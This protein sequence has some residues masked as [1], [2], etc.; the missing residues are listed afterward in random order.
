MQG[1][2]H[3][4]LDQMLGIQYPIIMAPMFLVSNARMVI[5]ALNAGITG[6]IPALN[7]RSVRE[8]K[9]AIREIKSD[10]DKPFGIN[11]IVNKSNILL[12]KQLDVVAEEKIGFVITSLGKPQA[13]I[14]RL[15]DAGIKVFCDVINLEHALKCEQLGADALIAVN[16]Q[17]GGHLGNLPPEELIPLLKKKTSLP[18][19]S[20]GGVSTP[21]DVKEILDMGADGLSIGSVFIASHEA[22]VADEYKEAIVNYGAEDIVITTRLS[23]TPCTVINTEYV[24]SIGTKPSFLEKLMHRG[25]M[26]KKYIKML[27][28]W[29]GMNKLRKSAKSAS[30]QNVWSAGISIENVHEI[31][32]VGQIAEYLVQKIKNY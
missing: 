9:E 23:G 30:Y 21:E 19:I 8:L 29:R 31:R 11:L 27:L 20:A 26:M 18:V 1:K 13:V 15:H 3:F 28:S 24:K 22:D 2:R 16:N 25:P 4:R 14:P 6:A 17:A 12:E 32:S 7:Y 10:S 5:A